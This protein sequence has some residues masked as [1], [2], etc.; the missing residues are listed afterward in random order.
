MNTVIASNPSSPTGK[1]ASENRS[2]VERRQRSEAILGDDRRVSFSD[3]RSENNITFA[4]FYLAGHY[5]CVD[6]Q[7]VQEV[8]FDQP[9]T[10]VPLS[11][12]DIAGLINLRG[13]IVTAIDLRT[14]LGFPQAED[15]SSQ[16]N[17]VVTTQSGALSLIVDQV[18][19]VM[20]ISPT[21]YEPTPP[22]LDRRLKEVTLGVFKTANQLLAILN[23][24]KIVNQRSDFMNE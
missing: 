9:M 24:E 13:Q 1:T 5:L 15:K 18:A 4:T 3:R 12:K 7:K 20:E 19:D 10:Q 6:V 22:T 21:L 16:M 2:P 17:I 8:L 11:R 23:V 14:M